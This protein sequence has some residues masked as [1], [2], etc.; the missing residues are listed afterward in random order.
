MTTAKLCW[1]RLTKCETG[2]L[3]NPLMHLFLYI[4]LVFS[5]AF[6]FFGHT[7]TVQQSTLFT[8]SQS[9]AGNEWVVVWG[10][11]GLLV[12]G[13]HITGLLLRTVYGLYMLLAAAAGGFYLWL[14]ATVIY[15]Q[16]DLWFQLTAAAIPN[17]LFWSWYTWQWYRRFTHQGDRTFPAFV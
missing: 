2:L 8:E 11:V 4:T 9:T 5:V 15:I 6:V 7:E 16:G 13:L 1:G 10:D 3:F 12:V 14:W 17:I